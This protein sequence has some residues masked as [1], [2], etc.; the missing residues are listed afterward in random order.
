M[1]RHARFYWGRR[2]G[3]NRYDFDWNIIRRDS[4][5][6]ITASEGRPPINTLAPQ[7]YVGDAPFTVMN[8]APYDGGVIF[9][10]RI[11]WPHPLDLW[12]DITVFD[13]S[14]PVWFRPSK[15]AGLG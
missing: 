6:V 5:V 8:I 7:R 10:V 11:D 15:F 14:D 2:N 3:M 9:A 12:T 13:R 1:P 4:V